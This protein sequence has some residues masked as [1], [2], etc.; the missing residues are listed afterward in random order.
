[1]TIRELPDGEDAVRWTHTTRRRR[2]ALGRRLLVSAREPA[3]H[4]PAARN[5]FD[6]PPPR[7]PPP[8]AGPDGRAGRA[9]GRGGG[10][11]RG[12]GR[13]WRTQPLL[14]ADRGRGPPAARRGGAPRP[15][16]R[17]P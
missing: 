11:L 5:R 8:A 12:D 15:P 2:A 4:R 7:R 3:H 1:M 6:R 13:R 16:P 10:Q 14:E 9:A 17:P